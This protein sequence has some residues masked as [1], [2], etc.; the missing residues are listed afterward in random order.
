MR[1]RPH[2]LDESRDEGQSIPP[3]MRAVVFD[4]PGAASVMRIATVPV[5]VPVM[6]EVLIRVTAAGINPIDAK[7]RAGRGVSAHLSALPGTLGFDVAGVVVKTPYELHPLPV[8]TRVFGMVAYPRTPGSYA[9]YAIA[10]TSSLAVIPDSMS[11][12]DAAA[13]PLAALTAWQAVVDIA[14]AHQGSRILVHAGAGGVGHLAVQFARHM[15]A[16]VTATAS[17]ANVSWLRELGADVV[18]D[19][20]TTRFEEVIGTVDIVID[21]VGNVTERTGSRSLQV[22]RQG[23]LLV[24]VPTGSWPEYAAEAAEARVRATSMKVIPD[25]Q[26]LATIGRLLA[27]GNVR[28]NVSQ[29]F[30]LAD[31]RRA[32]AVLEEGHT[33]GKLVLSMAEPA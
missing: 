11:D 5:P 18:I 1:V 33:R 15:G 31:A 12:T 28:I 24:Q 16:H 22:L 19:Y 4:E 20:S 30:P 10:S 21:L 14:L 26:T 13:V 25:G 17:G 8:G 7:T 3:T 32:H 9:E 29:V 27:E 2:R 23:G 6:D